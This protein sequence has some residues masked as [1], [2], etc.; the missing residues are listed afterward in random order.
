MGTLT[1]P[2]R[3][4]KSSGWVGSVPEEHELGDV[5]GWCIRHADLGSHIRV[6]FPEIAGKKICVAKV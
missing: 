2:R 5:A 1:V 6:S 3:V 4:R